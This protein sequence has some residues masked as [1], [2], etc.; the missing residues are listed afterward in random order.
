MA[1]KTENTPRS[2]AAIVGLVLGILAIITSWMPIINN[3]AFILG[4]IGVIFALVG[5]LGV[6]RGKKSGKGLAIAS[7][8]VNVLAI[9]IVLGTQSMYSAALDEAVNGPEVTTTESGSQEGSESEGEEAQTEDLAVGSAVTFEDGL[10]ITVDSV[11]TG[12][13]NY[14]GSSLIGIHVTYVNNSD[15]EVDYNSYNWKGRNAQGAA[16]DPV[17]YSEA[18]EDLSYGTLAPGG[19]VS[20]NIYFA[21][22]S[23]TAL[24]YATMVADSPAATWTIA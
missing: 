20:G 10:S 11:S 15:A 6:M 1:E 9:A 24:Y 21:G 22:D 14:D 12:L 5:L 3:L 7:V 16:T 23:V 8:V 2:A 13:V 4:G 18:T 19:T 17:F